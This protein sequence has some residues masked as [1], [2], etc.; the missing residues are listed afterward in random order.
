MSIRSLPDLLAAIEQAHLL[1]A[2]HVQQIGRSFTSPHFDSRQAAKRLIQ[3]GWLTAYQVNRL[4]QGQ[5]RNLVLGSYVLLERLGA[6][7]MGEVYKAR[8]REMQRVVALKLIR[9]N[10]LDNPQAVQR[11]HREV[12]AIAQLKHPNIVRAYDASHIGDTQFLVME[13]VPGIDLS[14]R[15]K[16]QGPLPVD[17][18]CDYI[19]QAACGLAHAHERGLIHRDIKPSNMLLTPEPAPDAPW[20]TITL[21][22]LGLARVADHKGDSATDTLTDSGHILGTPDFVAPEQARDSKK[23]DCRADL[24]SL[25]CT[26]YF[27]LTGRV[28][29]PAETATEK[30]IKH[31]LEEPERLERVRPEVPAEIAGLVRTLMAKRPEH[32]IQTAS[33][34]AKIITAGLQ[35]Q[36]WSESGTRPLFQRLFRVGHPA[37]PNYPS[38]TLAPTLDLKRAPARPRGSRFRPVLLTAAPVFGLCLIGWLVSGMFHASTPGLAKRTHATSTSLASSS[39]ETPVARNDPAWLAMVRKLPA[40]Q[41]VKAV[42]KRLAELNSRF[43]GKLEPRIENGVVMDVEL[44]SDELTDLSPLQGFPE[45]K[46]LHCDGSYQ[47]K[48]KLTDLSVLKGMQL[49]ELHCSSTEVAS[50]DFLRGMKLQELDCSATPVADLSPL[51]GMPLRSLNCIA[52]RVADL[53]PLEGMQLQILL[54][55]ATPIRDLTPLRG[56]PLV[57]LACNGTQVSDLSPL[58]GMPLKVLVCDFR[59]DRDTAILSSIKTLEKLNDRPARELL[60]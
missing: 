39:A 48:S 35:T 25:G 30:L 38:P 22:D 44:V 37:S 20:G 52:T 13:Y 18:V 42:A 54:C 56:M 57:R 41:Q 53:S 27:L 9:K 60:R 6:G 40:E 16:N 5:A 24:Y 15:V 49:T 31:A 45:L 21:L 33:E 1:D 28:P 46:V 19:R 12:Q 51:K 26:F 8:H 50:L 47:H 36:R 34:V 10:F 17:A 23:I 4:F 29:F 3:D 55:K 2:A 58:K 59:A 32:R 14:K 43:N 7:G 11:F